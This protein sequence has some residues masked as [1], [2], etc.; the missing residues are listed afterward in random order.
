MF[1]VIQHCFEPAAERRTNHR[2]FG[3][4]QHGRFGC[5]KT[6]QPAAQGLQL[7]ELLLDFIHAAPAVNEHLSVNGFKIINVPEL[8]P[9][10]AFILVT[11]Q[12]ETVGLKPMYHT[13]YFLIFLMAPDDDLFFLFS[14]N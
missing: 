4:V 5:A 6:A 8:D 14:G 12:Y 1:P 10:D 13:P 7:V 2:N 9:V 11:K 3:Y